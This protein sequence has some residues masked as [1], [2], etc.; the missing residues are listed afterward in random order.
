MKSPYF[1]DYFTLYFVRF[2]HSWNYYFIFIG[3]KGISKKK[4]PSPW[5][6]FLL[7]EEIHK[8]QKE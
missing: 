7:Q 8:Q 4:Q 2:I 6:N 3:G 5:E 1:I